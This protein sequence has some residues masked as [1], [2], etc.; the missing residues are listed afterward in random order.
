M[1]RTVPVSYVLVVYEAV[2]KETLLVIWSSKVRRQNLS[3]VVCIDLEPRLAGCRNGR[4]I[5]WASSVIAKFG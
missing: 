4:H 5:T 3:L 1:E 2:A